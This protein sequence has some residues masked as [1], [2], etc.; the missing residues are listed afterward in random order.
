MESLMKVPSKGR[1][2]LV[3]E[4]DWFVR[5]DIAAQFREEG[6]QVLE[7]ETGAQVLELLREGRSID[8]LVT[9]ITLADSMTGWDVAEAVRRRYPKVPVIYA[10]GGRD[11]SSRRVLDSVSVSKPFSAHDLL[12]AGSRLLHRA[13]T[14]VEKSLRAGNIRP[15]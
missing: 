10:S 11:V 4:D 6:W 14:S 5:E 9:D 2:A 3:V 12:S 8:I 13:L 7:A 15:V 1:T